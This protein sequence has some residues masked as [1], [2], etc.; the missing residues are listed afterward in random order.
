MASRA[1]RQHAESGIA[2]LIALIAITLVTISVMQFTHNRQVDYRRTAHWAQAKQAQL[3]A[4]DSIEFAR[5]LLAVDRLT[6]PSDGFSDAW[7]QYCQ[8][9]TPDFCP[10]A[11]RTCGLPPLEFFADPENSDPERSIALQIV[12]MTGRYNLNRLR[13]RHPTEV[14][15]EVARDLFILSEVNPDLIGPIVDWIDQDGE[16][17][18]YGGG[19][20]DPQYADTKPRYSP[21]NAELES[22]RELAL[23]KGMTHDDLV[24]LRPNVATLPSDAT[25]AININTAPRVVLRALRALDPAMG[26][27]SLIATILAERCSAPFGDRADLL[28]RI[29]EFPDLRNFDRWIRFDSSY[30]QLLATAKVDEVY[31]SIEALLHRTD[32]GIRVVYYLARRGPVIPGV[33]LSEPAPNGDLDFLGARRIGA[34]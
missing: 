4:D 20:E 24:R 32:Q 16:L 33:D 22:L 28:K 26:D 3:Y 9:N 27:E 1:R 17:Y 23:L 13:R 19:A 29:P 25:E 14:E 12:D 18:R 2:L 7:A 30:F 34:F 6:T 10:S 8:P 11:T 15:R 31:Q 21:R 5:I